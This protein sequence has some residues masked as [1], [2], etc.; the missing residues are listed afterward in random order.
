[1]YAFSYIFSPIEAHLN[2]GPA[3]IFQFLIFIQ[4]DFFLFLKTKSIFYPH[5]VQTA[6]DSSCWNQQPI[7]RRC[8][9]FRGLT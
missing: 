6:S 1:M 8:V 4:L 9:I 5:F 3:E 7:I 2:G